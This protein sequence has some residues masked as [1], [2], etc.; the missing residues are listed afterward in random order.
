MGPLFMLFVGLGLTG[1]VLS[2]NNDDDDSGDSPPSDTD[3]ER[4]SHEIVDGTLYFGDST[5]G[6]DIDLSALPDEADGIYEFVA[7]DG[8]DT[9]TGDPGETGHGGTLI[10][11]AGDDI[12]EIT[13]GFTT[14]A[15]GEG[16]DTISSSSTAGDASRTIL[17]GPGDDILSGGSSLSVYGEEGND[18]L[19]FYT[20]AMPFGSSGDGGPGDDLF[21]INYSPAPGDGYYTLGVGVA[22]GAGSD[23]FHLDIQDQIGFDPF[24]FSEGYG[25]QVDADGALTYDESSLGIIDFE[26]GSD[27][28]ILESTEGFENFDLVEIELVE[29]EYRDYNRD[30]TYTTKTGTNVNLTFEL[31]SG[32]GPYTTNEGT[33][34]TSITSSISMPNT[35]GIS[36]SDITVLLPGGEALL[37][38]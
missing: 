36:E 6:L 23:T 30:G 32:V 20:T 11:G 37:V 14:I 31:K 21:E 28:L 33:E 4:P 26:P 13:S 38:A 8:D 29:E 12:V 5:E 34:F 19:D 35:T 22:G 24:F 3:D 15:G 9:I 25:Y 17:G 18:T 10:L 16:N 2:D 7:S 1:L 27:H